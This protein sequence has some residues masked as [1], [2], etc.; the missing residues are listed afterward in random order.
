MLK[1]RITS[2]V[3]YFAICFAIFLLI[4]KPVFLLYNWNHGTS[5]MSLADWGAVYYHGFAIDL[6]SAGY[7]TALPLLLVWASLL[8]PRFRVVPWLKVYN[9]IV[10][11]C[12]ALITTADAALYEFW[13]FK[14]DATVF[15][16]IGDPKNAF[17][18]VSVGYVL[19]RLLV[20]IALAALFYWLLMLPFRRWNQAGSRPRWYW[21]VLAM[22]V[23]GGLTFGAI[24]GTRIW[25]NTPTRAFFSKTTYL[26]H[27]AL[28]PMFNLI[29]T[30][31]KLD[32]FDKEFKVFPEEECARDFEGLFPTSGV[33][34]DT[35]IHNQRPNVLVIVMEGFGS[36][37]IKS[38]GGMDDV[39]PYMS[40]I[41]D[42]S[43]AFTN[44]YCS[45]FR[46]DR[47]IVSVVSGYL[48]QPTTSI[49]RYTHKVNTLP[50]LPKTL[51]TVG[52]DTQMLYASD[53]TFFGMSEYFFA[54]GHDKL[55]SQDSFPAE[56]RSTKWGVP[57]HE[58]AAWLYDDIQRRHQ[59][60]GKPWYTTFLTIS[61]HTPFDVPYHRLEDEKLNSFAYT[62]E[63]IGQFIDQL[64]QSPAWDD[65]LI[66]ITADHGFNHLP[67]A[68]PDF[69]FIPFILTGGAANEPRRID[70]FCSQTDIAATVL[71]QMGLP[72]DDF[73]FSRD[74][75]AD[76]YR[77]PFAFNTFNNGFNLRDSTGYTVY[78]NVAGKATY[79]ADE[80][81]E[82]IGK[83]I[84]QTLY[85]DLSAR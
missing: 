7:L 23:L 35:L 56:Q 75:T 2:I 11:I 28:N 37:F 36:L 80:R 21:A 61:S 78:D 26:N 70:T 10:A 58:A 74:V 40:R 53:I 34:V 55:V 68:S 62:D 42:E 12:L 24:R 19:V 5:A 54:T 49:M 71:G 38:L 84:L 29:Y 39:A 67:V 32:K 6:A 52:Y 22:L 4:Q 17:A 51:K 27:A 15:M 14:L 30:S 57:D 85:D 3:L 9:L 66:V 31:T 81:R 1:R 64:K 8:L 41:V 72:H 48:G 25:P 16:Y 13:E 44:C 65:L 82:H 69:P 60:G 79:G 47:G 83:V 73:I 20:V 45:S 63:A 77:Y 18:S 46:T 43:I 50:G 33:T 76:T 59:E